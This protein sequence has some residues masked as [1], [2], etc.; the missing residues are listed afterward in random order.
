GL[1]LAERTGSRVFN[2]LWPYVLNNKPLKYIFI[3][4]RQNEGMAIH[5]YV[6][7]GLLNLEKYDIISWRRFRRKSLIKS[8]E[9]SH[10]AFFLIYC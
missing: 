6:L 1:S 10:P 5:L 4:L 2:S 9:H 3:I 7:T 8:M